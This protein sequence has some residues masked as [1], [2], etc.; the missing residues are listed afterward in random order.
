MPKVADHELKQLLEDGLTGGQQADLRNALDA[1]L[2]EPSP[3]L[4]HRLVRIARDFPV[5]VRAGFGRR[6]PRYALPAL[7]AAALFLGGYEY[8]GARSARISRGFRASDFL[9]ALVDP[10]NEPGDVF[11]ADV[12]LLGELG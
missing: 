8:L 1:P 3:A 9:G 6:L 11:D 10:A 4:R 12:N 5:E 7:L 2:P